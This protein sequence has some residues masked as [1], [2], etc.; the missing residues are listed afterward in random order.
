MDEPARE[1]RVQY[2]AP[3]HA[4]RKAIALAMALAVAVVAVLKLFGP[5]HYVASAIVAPT[6]RNTMSS[7]SLSQF[8]GLA[9]L[10]GIDLGSNRQAPIFDRF[11]Y[12]LRSPELAQRLVTNREVLAAYYPAWD[13]NRHQWRQPTSFLQRLGAMLRGQGPDAYDLA[14]ILDDHITV[15]SIPSADSSRLVSSMFLVQYTDVDASRA[16]NML[17]LVLSTD[18]DTLR[19]R[20]AE[21]ARLQANYLEQKLKVVGTQEFRE[22]LIKLYSEQQQTLMLAGSG[23]AYAGELVAGDILPSKKAP[24]RLLLTSLIA[25]SVTFCV[26]YFVAIVLFNLEEAGRFRPPRFLHREW[27]PPSHV[28]APAWAP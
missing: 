25:A 21:T 19:D 23:N 18:N 13:A 8:A 1:V 9:S 14:Q 15:H 16:E 10:A 11:M 27:A 6:G 20:A 5:G 26:A 3:L 12:L 24:R 7:G 22:T 2:L 4:Y 28:A 17:K